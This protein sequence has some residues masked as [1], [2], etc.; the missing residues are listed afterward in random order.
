MVYQSEYLLASVE[1]AFS[2]VLTDMHLLD[3]RLR[4]K[5]NHVPWI[6]PQIKLLMR[7]KDFHK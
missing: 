6:T 4:L 3:E 7:K 5:D 2:M 1:I